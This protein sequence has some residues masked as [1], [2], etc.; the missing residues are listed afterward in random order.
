MQN[1]IPQS[2]IHDLIAQTDITLLID[3]YVPLKKQGTSF[4]A[5]CPFHHEKTPSFNVVPRKQFYYCFGCGASGNVIGFLMAHLNLGFVEAVTLLAQRLGMVVPVSQEKKSVA[6]VD[7]TLYQ[8]LDQ[9]NQYF[10]RLLKTQGQTAAEYLVARGISE[11]MIERFQ[12]GYAQASWHGLEQA[13]RKYQAGLLTTGMLIQNEQGKIYDRYRDRLMFPIHDR[14]G[15]IIGF[16][17]R[18]LAADQKPKYLNSPETPLFHKGRELYGL[19]QVSQCKTQL[20]QLIVVEGYLDVIS[21]TQY[22]VTGA[23][24][25]LGTTMGVYQFQLLRKYAQK[26]IFCF[27]GDE[28]GK[29]AAWRALESSLSTVHELELRF[30]FLPEND[31]PDSFVRRMGGAHF[32]QSIQHALPWSDFFFTQLSDNLSLNTL[33]GRSQLIQRAM[34]YLRQIQDSVYRTLLLDELAKITRTEVSRILS[35]MQQTAALPAPTHQLNIGRSPLRIA[36]ALLLQYP[37][38]FQA[39]PPTTLLLE[40]QSEDEGFLLLQA[41]LAQITQKDKLS[42]AMLIEYWRDSPWFE[43]LQKLACWDHRVP[44]ALIEKELE[45]MITFLNRQCLEKQIQQLLAKSRQQRLSADEQSELQTLL[46]RRHQL[47]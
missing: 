17:G 45:D 34:G 24:A 7:M 33:S 4:T 39:T 46:K 11:E 12:L 19:Y 13:F 9:V 31:D 35:L 1:L 6:Q 36:M 41:L 10:R 21:L 15:K 38:R 16:G 42:T 5:C 3:E 25:T 2:F 37:E 47:V 29:K 20:E 43:S 26:V 30:M 28:A 8:L 23:V 18:V 27:D 14:K 22:G 40:Y 32:L 44:D